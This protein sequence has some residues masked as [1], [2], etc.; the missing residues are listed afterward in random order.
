LNQFS[1]PASI[2]LSTRPSL[3]SCW[4]PASRAGA[5]KSTR[6]SM[7]TRISTSCP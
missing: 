6:Y 7:S 1:I 3:C 5:K 4:L 2:D